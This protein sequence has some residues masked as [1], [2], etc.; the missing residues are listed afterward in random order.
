MK[1]LT[2]PACMKDPIVSTKPCARSVKTPTNSQDAQ[3][4]SPAVFKALLTSLTVGLS[5][6]FIPLLMTNTAFAKENDFYEWDTPYAKALYTNEARRYLYLYPNITCLGVQAAY[7]ANTK[8]YE[9]LEKNTD[10]K[11]EKD[12]K[13]QM[14]TIGREGGTLQTVLELIKDSCD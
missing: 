12:Y 7:D 5:C 14:S 1:I 3:N 6:G 10:P 2:I 4:S 13:H 11:V 9:I 8:M